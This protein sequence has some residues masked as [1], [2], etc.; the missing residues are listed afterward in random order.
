VSILLYLTYRLFSIIFSNLNKQRY[1]TNLALILLGGLSQFSLQFYI[2]RPEILGLVFFVLGLIYL[3]KFIKNIDNNNN[4]NKKSI[5]MACFQFGLSSVFH[6]NFLLLSGLAF[7]YCVYLILNNK[8]YNY[9]KF[10]SAFFL[11]IAFFIF[12]FVVNFDIAIDQLFN[13]VGEVATN[14]APSVLN[15]FSVLSGNNAK[16]AMHNIYL[17]L[18]MLTLILVL[19]SLLFYLVKDSNKKKDLYI[20]KL[21]KALVI[22]IFLILLLMQPYRPNYLLVSYL[23]IVTLSF[24]IVYHGPSIGSILDTNYLSSFKLSLLLLCLGLTPLSVPIFHSAKNY[25]SNGMYD[26]HHKTLEVLAPFL[27]NNQ[28]IFIT[29][30]Q[31]LPLFSN[32][33]HV[34]F[35]NTTRSKRRNIHW[36]FP[37]ANSP[38]DAF[39]RLM[40]E[41]IK[42]EQNLMTNALWGALN[43]TTAFN[44]SMSIACLSL[45]GWRGVI[46]LYKPKVVFQ[47]KQN[48]FL[49]SS[50]VTPSNKCFE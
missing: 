19:L 3:I 30:A 39:K 21:F 27:H 45:K 35:K 49:T 43:K 16:S 34:D 6:P 41:D 42:N 5:Y 24:F 17:Q 22:V 8:K 13:R 50:E 33:I 48:I 40:S 37:V 10:T 31:L 20:N 4:N 15:I 29:T 12:W 9:L 23:S 47:D 25:V 18:H 11:P 44:E 14:S 26:N 28:H 46:N 38:G 36:Y 1:A 32:N 7:I 2:N